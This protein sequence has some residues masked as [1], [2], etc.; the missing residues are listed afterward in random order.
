MVEE[1]KQDSEE[2][3][4]KLAKGLVELYEVFPELRPA[5]DRIS[6]GD[7]SGAAEELEKAEEELAKTILGK[8]FSRGTGKTEEFVE[9]IRKLLKRMKVTLKVEAA[10]AAIVEREGGGADLEKQNTEMIKLSVQE[11]REILS[12]TEELEKRDNKDIFED[13]LEEYQRIMKTGDSNLI[14]SGEFLEKLNVLLEEVGM[15]KKERTAIMNVLRSGKGNLEPG[16]FGWSS[17]MIVVGSSISASGI[18]MMDFL[19]NFEGGVAGQSI[20]ASIGGTVIGL[21]LVQGGIFQIINEVAQ[22]YDI[23]TLKKIFKR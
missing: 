11:T 3:I 6:E 7:L 16:T 5:F 23:E 8:K 18:L 15:S 20:R 14:S 13:V 17:F 10:A 19:S 2:G 22:G 21:L 9:N 12:L 4:E 1:E